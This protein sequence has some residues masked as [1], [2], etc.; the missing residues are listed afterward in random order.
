MSEKID[1]A[2]VQPA[3]PPADDAAFEAENET[4]KTHKTV[5]EHAKAATA[6]EQSMTLLE[7]IRLY[8]KAIGWSILIS[9][10]IVMEGYDISLIN[11][12]CKL[13]RPTPPSPHRPLLISL[14]PQTLSRNSI[15]SMANC[16]LMALMRFP[17]HGKLG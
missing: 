2:G 4:S 1:E 12:F 5:V 13:H 17:L 15:A 9:T 10:C 7:G 11:N 8:P 14:N 3:V 16:S 6:K